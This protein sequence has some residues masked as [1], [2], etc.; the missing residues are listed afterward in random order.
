MARKS[1]EWR[2]LLNQGS[3][4]ETGLPKKLKQSEKVGH[5]WNSRTLLETVGHSWKQSGAA[6]HDQAKI[7]NP[8]FFLQKKFWR[9]P[10]FFLESSTGNSWKQSEKVGART[11]DSA[12][13]SYYKGFQYQMPWVTARNFQKGS[14]GNLGELEVAQV[15]CPIGA[16]VLDANH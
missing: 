6:R 8:Q 15:C 12:E 14:R 7:L 1:V 13:K 16:I 5:S 3:N 10:L 2:H 4:G 11:F 9:N